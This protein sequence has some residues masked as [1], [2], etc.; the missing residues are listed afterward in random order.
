MQGLFGD[1]KTLSHHLHNST[2][3]ES[4]TS[5]IIS[6]VLNFY[7]LTRSLNAQM[8]SS[9]W[10]VLSYGEIKL[11]LQIFWV[12]LIHSQNKTKIN[13]LALHIAG[14]P[15]LPQWPATYLT[16]W[17]KLRC[18]YCSLLTSCFLQSAHHN[19]Q[20]FFVCLFYERTLPV[21]GVTLSCTPSIWHWTW[22][23]MGTRQTLDTLLNVFR[24][25]QIA[26]VLSLV[27]C[28]LS[29]HLYYFWESKEI[30]NLCKQD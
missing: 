5:S 14:C 11:P 10:K 28:N 9:N 1:E 17:S 22:H 27:F 25:F 26:Y 18:P 8:K 7:Y 19:L 29:T 12:F 24:Y 16:T 2:Y 23:I 21:R 13:T 20:L 3:W 6:I 30:A 4:V 15:S